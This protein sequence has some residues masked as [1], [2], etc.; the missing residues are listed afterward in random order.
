MPA[1]TISET[2]ST[3]QRRFASGGIRATSGHLL[4]LFLSL[5][6]DLLKLL[7]NIRMIR[8][9]VRRHS[10]L[11]Q[12]LSDVNAKLQKIRKERPIKTTFARSTLYALQR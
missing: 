7:Q 1:S 3:S 9:D 2:S 6:D 8:L 12:E 5:E 4:G 10:L 11:A